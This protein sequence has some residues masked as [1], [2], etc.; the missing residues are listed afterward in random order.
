MGV[1]LALCRI[2]HENIIVRGLPVFNRALNS[3]NLSAL[4]KLLR[5]MPFEQSPELV[6][7]LTAR[8][9]QLR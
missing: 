9:A 1:C 6:K 2:D 8:I 5:S 4:R 3:G 7:Q